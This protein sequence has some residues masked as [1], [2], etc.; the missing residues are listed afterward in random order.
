MKYVCWECANFRNPKLAQALKSESYHIGKTIYF[1]MHEVVGQFFDYNLWFKNG[2]QES[3]TLPYEFDTSLEDFMHDCKCTDEKEMLRILKK[4]QKYQLTDFHYDEDMGLLK[5]V[6]P[7]LMKMMD[8]TQKQ[9]VSDQGE[10]S[11]IE[12]LENYWVRKANGEV[13]YSDSTVLVHQII[14]EDK[15]VSNTKKSKLK[16]SN[17]K[18]DNLKQEQTSTDES[19]TVQETLDRIAKENKKIK[20]LS[21]D[22]VCPF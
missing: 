6:C 2:R 18:R 12:F 10:D 7:D 16:L 22:D 11:E 1:T 3:E 8:R 14:R 5:L 15:K 21:K 9:N 20:A 17:T 19:I 4:F 13:V